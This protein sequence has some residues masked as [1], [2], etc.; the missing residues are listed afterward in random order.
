MGISWPTIAITLASQVFVA[1][2]AVRLA[3]GRFRQ[4]KWWERKYEAYTEMLA[5]LHR[6]K[7]SLLVEANLNLNG[8]EP[9]PEQKAVSEAD[10]EAG[11]AELM[12]HADLGDFL[13]S[14]HACRLLR[15]FG[16]DVRQASKP[17]VMY[18]DYLEGNIEAADRFIEGLKVAAKKD[19]G[20]RRNRHGP[21]SARSPEAAL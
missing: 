1:W 16:E 12:R 8:Q 10:H 21:S 13:I 3:L 11:S 2:V 19:L 5:S 18:G 14:P 6:M 9:T 4:E 17:G 20:I 15:R 7:K